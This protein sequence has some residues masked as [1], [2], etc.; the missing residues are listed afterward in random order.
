MDVTDDYDSL[1]SSDERQRSYWEQLENSTKYLELNWL[2]G[3][4]GDFQ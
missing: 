2:K 4:V 3:L 1:L